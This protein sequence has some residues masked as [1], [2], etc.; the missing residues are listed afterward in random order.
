MAELKNDKGVT[1]YACFGTYAGFGIKREPGF[2]YSLILGFVSLS[3][4]FRDIEMWVPNLHAYM[5]ELKEENDRLK[6]E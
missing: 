5:R 3:V 4:I 2:R 6:G 1:F